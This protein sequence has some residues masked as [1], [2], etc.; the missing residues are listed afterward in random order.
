VILS[1]YNHLLLL[2][3]GTGKAPAREDIRA[4]VEWLANLL[5]YTLERQASVS[6]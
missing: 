1:T 5:G 3:G 6:Y 4:V 2:A